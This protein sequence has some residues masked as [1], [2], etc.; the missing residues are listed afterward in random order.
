LTSHVL[1]HA[2]KHPHSLTH[3][4]CCYCHNEYRCDIGKRKRRFKWAV[5]Q[6]GVANRLAINAANQ[7]HIKKWRRTTC[8]YSK[9]YC[10]KHVQQIVSIVVAS[11]CCRK[12]KHKHKQSSII[13]PSREIAIPVVVVVV[14]RLAD[15]IGNATSFL[16]WS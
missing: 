4:R 13:S 2:T 16:A 11:L 8:N 14:F 5:C 7:R 1:L 6:G 15:D 3:V 10:N 9:C 12:H